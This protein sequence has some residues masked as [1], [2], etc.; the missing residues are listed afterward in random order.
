MIFNF[1]TNKQF[2]TD[3][4]VN[5]EV[6]ETVKEARLLGTIISNDLK[7]EA[8]T[9]F[10]V[11]DSNKR[12]RLLHNAY[13]FTRNKQ[14]LKQIYMLQVRCKLE[15]AAPVWHHS[16]TKAEI[17]SLERVQRAACRI[18]FGDRYKS[19]EDSLQVLKMDSLEN[20][21]NKLTLSF[22]KS[23]LKLDKMRKLFPLNDSNHEM[24]KRSFEKYKVIKAKTERYKSSAVINIQRMLNEE[25]EKNVRTYQGVVS[26]VLRTYDS[27]EPISLRKFT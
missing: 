26:N 18:I 10:L 8:N 9:Q 23:S 14:H 27:V 12:L 13:K 17:S 20:R 19:Y 6:I 16:L 2:C 15:Q 3:I 22:A 5:G 25:E 7:W 4:R 11:K 21:R 1:S 24:V